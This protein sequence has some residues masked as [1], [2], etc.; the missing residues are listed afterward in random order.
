L[1]GGGTIVPSELAGSASFWA[2][3][4]LLP[5]PSLLELFS[6][7]SKL[8][9]PWLMLKVTGRV[10]SIA[11]PLSALKKKVQFE[12]AKIR[13]GLETDLLP[14]GIGQAFSVGSGIPGQRPFCQY[15]MECQI[16]V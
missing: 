2:G 11:L 15:R 5:F 8:P 16:S 3:D 4:Q 10:V 6:D 7:R 13:A 1:A 14:V 12:G 9:M